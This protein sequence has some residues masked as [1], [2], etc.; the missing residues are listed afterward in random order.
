MHASSNAPTHAAGKQSVLHTASRP[1]RPGDS[2][3]EH[4]KPEEIEVMRESQHGVSS[5][6][7]VCVRVHVRVRVRACIIMCDHVCVCVHART[8]TC[9]SMSE[10]AAEVV[11]WVC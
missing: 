11:T 2:L 9:N 10:G 6:P 4:L 1:L 8:H 3:T 5:E 7:P